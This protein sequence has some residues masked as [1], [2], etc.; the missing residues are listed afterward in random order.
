MRMNEAFASIGWTRG[1][2]RIPHLDDIAPQG[3]ARFEKG[4]IK[5]SMSNGSLGVWKG[6][7]NY[8]DSPN[9]LTLNA[10]EVAEGNRGNG[11]GAEA[12]RAVLEV[13]RLIGFAGT[14][15]VEAS[16]IARRKSPLDRA[17]LGAWYKR[18]GFTED[19][20]SNGRVFSLEIAAS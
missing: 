1:E 17:A 3:S 5:I 10:I 15:Y 13:L 19:P 6:S 8:Y 18:H 4:D 7:V 16:P 11:L 2:G 9:S 20:D 12:L 14:L